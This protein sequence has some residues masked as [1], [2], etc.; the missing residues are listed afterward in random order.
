MPENQKI[1]VTIS[2]QMASGGAY[3]GHLV[4]RTLGYKYVEREVLYKAAEELDVDIAEIRFE[5]QNFGFM[6]NLM[7][8][9]F[10]GTPEM[11]YVPPSRRPIYEP[12]LF[13][14]ESRIIKTFADQY[15]SVIIGR[16]GYSVLRGRPGVVNVYIHAPMD[17]RINR[18]RSFHDITREQARDELETS[19]LQRIKFL[20]KMTN[21]DQYDARNYHVCID[22]EAAGF[23]TAQ[24]MIIDLVKRRKEAL[25]L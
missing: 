15:N 20:K 14:V 17:F 1:V 6:Q 24:R 10:F 22:A 5:E 16:G 9:F 13:E 25:G 7:K 8:S 23:E 2:R 4:A 18:L 3:I 19:D 21:T 11:A 12:E